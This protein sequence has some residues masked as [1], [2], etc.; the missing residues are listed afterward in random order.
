MA[1]IF[2]VLLLGLGLAGAVGF[3]GKLLYDAGAADKVWNHPLPACRVLKDLVG[4]ED[5]VQI[6]GTTEVIISAADRS[7]IKPSSAN[8]LYHLDLSKPDARPVLLSGSTGLA[9]EPQGLSIWNEGGV[10]RLFAVNHEADQDAVEI[11]ELA[12]DQLRTIRSVKFPGVRTLNAVQALGPESFFASQ[13]LGAQSPWGQILE[14]YLR[15]AKGGVWLYD[16]GNLQRSLD[17]LL[18]PNGLALS[19]DGQYVYVASMLGRS[20]LVFQHNPTTHILSLEREI[21]LNT[22]PDNLRWS[23]DQRLLVGAQ[24]HLLALAEHLKAPLEKRAPSQLIAIKGLPK[25]AAIEEIF[26]SDGEDLSSVSVGL[27]VGSHWI[28]G[29]PFDQGIIICDSVS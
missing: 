29:S 7:H 4:A 12:G 2:G 5:I 6:P 22:A 26:S 8:G 9:W 19:A 21:F 3:G 24:L 25:E 14:R 20:L 18:T 13:D 16:Q 15:L 17:G 28:M 11:M 1:K 27:Q 10:L 23:P